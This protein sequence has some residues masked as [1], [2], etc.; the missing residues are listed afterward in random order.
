MLTL[1]CVYVSLSLFPCGNFGK[2]AVMS[3]S[4]VGAL[5]A[6]SMDLPVCM[7]SPSEVL[8]AQG[9]QEHRPSEAE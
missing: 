7:L 2:W 5:G 8:A 3:W 4:R 1:V 6:W 9:C